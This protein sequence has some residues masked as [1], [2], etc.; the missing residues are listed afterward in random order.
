MEV[1]PLAKE[2][3]FCERQIAVYG[4]DRVRAA[5]PALAE[6]LKI[7]W[8]EGRTFLAVQ[9]YLADVLAVDDRRRQHKEIEKD[10]EEQ[11]QE[12]QLRKKENAQALRR[13][14]DEL[15]ASDRE[16]I[17]SEVVKKN[18]FLEKHP[19]IIDRFCLLELEKRSL[20]VGKR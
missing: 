17:R 14:W 5:L 11:E 10:R 18:P 7:A 2:L 15:S 8:P 12:L 9:S 1:E 3:E 6:R 13:I 20:N 16:S 19:I 4:K